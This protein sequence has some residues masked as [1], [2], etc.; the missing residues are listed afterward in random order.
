MFE[1]GTQTA[2][3]GGRRQRPC[4]CGGESEVGYEAGLYGE[5]ETAYESG[6]YGEYGSYGSYGETETGY[7]TGEYGEYNE[8]ETGEYGEY[9][10]AETGS[11]YGEYRDGETGYESGAYEEAEDRFLPL[12]PVVGKVLGGVLGGLTKEAESMYAGEYGETEYGESE[13]GEAEEQFLNEIMMEVLGEEEESE[14]ILSPAQESEFAAN[15][16]EV[17]NEEEME[18]FLGRLVNTI[19]R[20]VQGVKNAAR[21]PQGRALIDAVKPLARAAL[22][23]LGGAMGSALAPGVGTA[24]GRNLGM[25]VGPL[26]EVEMESEE[27][28]QVFELAR[29]VVR[30]TAAAAN[31]AAAA[32]PEAPPELL[33]ELSVF[34]A[35]RRL[36][37]PLFSRGLRAVSPLAR[38][39][40]GRRFGGPGYRGYPRFRGQRRYS[41]WRGARGWGYRRYGF[42]PWAS[43]GLAAAEPPSEPEPPPPQPG[44]RW[45]AV[46]I[47]APSP[48]VAEPAPSAEPPPAASQPPEPGSATE[49]EFS[50]NGDG[51]GSR[52]MGGGP[53][54]RWVRR[55]GKIILLDV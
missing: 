36:A 12:I 28:G 31:H 51:R 29:R 54:G 52:R 15:L 17:S 49:S 23:A 46:P 48:S 2:E 42:Q 1:A 11:E 6:E 25:T 34:R 18:Q 27:E 33:G 4:R 9:G 30:L 26:F 3:Y 50:Q 38:G 39:F 10:E 53:S 35:A 44:Y 22:P 21:S 41:P 37:R 7:E 43:A 8:G 24:L 47:G 45:V 19:G 40:Y 16:L 13:A 20:V 32:P 14:S 5:G 55:P